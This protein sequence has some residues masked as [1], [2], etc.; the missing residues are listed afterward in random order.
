VK[1]VLEGIVF[2]ACTSAVNVG[3]GRGNS[4]ENFLVLGIEGLLKLECFI[5]ASKMFF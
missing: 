5:A 3:N 4:Y 2:W 1:G